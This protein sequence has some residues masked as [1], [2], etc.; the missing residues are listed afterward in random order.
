MHLITM[1]A[2]SPLRSTPAQ[3][4]SP[5]AIFPKRGLPGGV[6]IC[7]GP[8]FTGYCG[9]NDPSSQCRI[10][11]TGVQTPRSIGPD[12]NGTCLLYSRGGCTGTIIASLRYP[13]LGS[14]VP[15]FASMRC[16]ADSHKGDGPPA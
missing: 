16:F 4:P 14:G 2:A 6:Y 9:W 8:D 15:E 1:T 3:S 10:P 11:G 7:T 12:E 5:I 13:G